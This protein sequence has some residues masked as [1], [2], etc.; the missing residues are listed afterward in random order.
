MS[1]ALYQAENGRLANASPV[2]LIVTTVPVAEES[3][4]DWA[5]VSRNWWQYAKITL[6]EET[7]PL[8][9]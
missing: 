4:P 7:V 8:D 1:D 9:A 6:V 5:K 3:R 2:P